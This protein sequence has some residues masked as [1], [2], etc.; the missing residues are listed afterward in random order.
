MAT[1]ISEFPTV[2]K[3]SE[4]TAFNR[5]AYVQQLEDL[6]EHFPTFVEEI[7]PFITYIGDDLNNFIKKDEDGEIAGTLKVHEPVDLNDCATM[8]YVMGGIDYAIDFTREKIDEVNDTID[9]NL[10]TFNDTTTDLSNKI[11]TNIT[12]INTNSNDIVDLDTK[13]DDL[14]TKLTDN[15]IRND[16]NGSIDGTLKVKD[17]VDD[18]DCVTKVYLHSEISNVYNYVDNEIDTVNNK[19]NDS[20]DIVQNSI[21][22]IEKTMSSAADYFDD[23]KLGF[24]SI[25]KFTGDGATT[26][27]TLTNKYVEDLEFYVDVIVD[28]AIYDDDDYTL[29][30]EDTITFDVAPMDGAKI[31]IKI[32]KAY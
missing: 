6:Y 21:N 11:D 27:F 10:V 15:Y 29:S 24:R 13:I 19:I 4:L 9:T 18:Q 23:N 31:V 30:N 3:R 12:N 22:N 1:T 8:D 5:P 28:R 14:D 32:L 26:E 17:P 16:V 20:I 25:E 7:N 2:L